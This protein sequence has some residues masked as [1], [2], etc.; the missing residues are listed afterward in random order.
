MSIEYLAHRFRT[1]IETAIQEGAL[2]A[3]F[4]FRIFPIGCCGDTCDLLAQY[5]L[6][7]G[8]KTKRV[9]GS[10]KNRSTNNKQ[11]HAWLQYHNCVI[12]DLT[13]DQFKD[14]SMFLFNSNPV[15]VGKKNG[16]YRLFDIEAVE[17]FK[18]L[19]HLDFFCQERLAELYKIVLKFIDR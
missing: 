15:Y 11:T 8:I 7:N 10:F 12:I 19:S 9:L 14:D 17:S 1:A 18:G 4:V 2:N 13:G 3:D 6:D 16:F 5:Y